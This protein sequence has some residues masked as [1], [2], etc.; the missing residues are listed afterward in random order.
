MEVYM[1]ISIEERIY[2]EERLKKTINTIKEQLAQAEDDKERAINEAKEIK[3][4]F[5]ETQPIVPESMSDLNTIVDITQNIRAVKREEQ[6]QETKNVAVKKLKKLLSSPYFGRVDF[7]EQGERFQDNIYIGVGTLIDEDYEMLIYDWRAPVCSL[8]YENEE[9]KAS[10]KCPEGTI[11]GEVTLKRQFGIS[12]GHLDYVFNSS[13]K[14][15]DDILQKTLSKSSDEK[16]KTIITSIQKEQNKVIRDEDNSVLIVQGPAGSGKTS[17]ALHRVAYILYKY[18]NKNVTSENV[19][20]FSPNDIFNDYIS[21]VLPELGEN[22]AYQTTFMEYVRNSLKGN[23]RIEDSSEQMEYILSAKR[24]RDYYLRKDNITFKTSVLFAEVIKR[25]VDY[26]EREGVKFSDINFKGFPIIKGE[27]I[28]SLFYTTYSKW[29]MDHRFKEII[30]DIEQR[31]KPVEKE[32]L[33]QIEEELS[34]SDDFYD[35]I[36]SMSRV[37]LKSE[38]QDLKGYIRRTLSINPLRSYKNLLS[39]DKLFLNL[40][41]G[42]DLPSNIKEILTQSFNFLQSGIIKYEDITP[43]LYINYALGCERA[44]NSIKYVI[45]DEAQDYS[46]F[47]YLIIKK[48]FPKA[49]F[50]ILGDINQSI[51]PNVNTLDYNVIV[52]I[53]GD[54]KSSIMNLTKSYRCTTEISNFTREILKAYDFENTYREGEKPKIIKSLDEEGKMEAVIHDVEAMKA[55]GMESIGII[56]RTASKASRVYKHLMKMRNIE[57]EIHLLQKDD[58]EFNSGITVTPSYLAKGLEFDGVIIVDGDEEEYKE[59]GERKLFYT[60]CT[61]ALHRLHIHFVNKPSRFIQDIDPRLY[62]GSKSY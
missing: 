60:I 14:I 59:E 43:L 42:L 13:L 17:I 55:S 37:K 51:N 26:I 48:L 53:F 22:N 9:G 56:C 49:G 45:I 1:S 4:S 33:K 18:A 57:E 46:P 31:I 38:L 24:N 2:E 25:Y 3:K 39:N 11:A 7:L 29:P 54:R 62:T 23:L 10:Y 12:K 58:S 15:D 8:F 16:M 40:A 20:I 36:E 52:D 21:G 35:D 44:M 32:R 27:E 34:E 19:V 6:R 47:Q 5:W 50:T 41:Q 28:K 61:R 30:Q